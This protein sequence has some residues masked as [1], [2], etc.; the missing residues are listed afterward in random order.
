MSTG[1]TELCPTCDSDSTVRLNFHGQDLHEC[2]DCGARFEGAEYDGKPKQIR[3]K[4]PY[5]GDTDAPRRK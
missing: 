2:L 1:W 5:L 4:K 3:V